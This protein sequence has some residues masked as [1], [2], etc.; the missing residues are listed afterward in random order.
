MSYIDT[1]SN[2][3][4]AG[5]QGINTFRGNCE[6]CNPYVALG[7]LAMYSSYAYLFVEFAVKRFIIKPRQHKL[8]REES[9]RKKLPPPAPIPRLV[10]TASY[11]F[12]EFAAED[13]DAAVGK[14]T[15]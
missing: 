10:Q 4:N 8:K 13:V 9:I 11:S 5:L 15:K 14:K 3:S 7:S 1:V 6:S 2:Q 12:H